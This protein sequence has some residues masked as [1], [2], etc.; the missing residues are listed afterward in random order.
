MSKKEKIDPEYYM[1]K[2]PVSKAIRYMAIPMI[3]MTMIDVIYNMTDAYFI[4]M[5]N[6]TAMLA[7]ITLAMPF[8]V[9][10]MAISMLFSIGGS[11]FVSRLMGEKNTEKTKLVS[12]TSFWF[13][14]ISGAIVGVV[15]L[16]FLTPL[17]HLFGAGGDVFPYAR[18]YV[19]ILAAGSPFLIA[20]FVLS[21][22][23]RGEGASKVALMGLL[24]SVLAN[25]ILDP[26]FIFGLNGGI[27]GAAVALIV[28]N[29][30]SVS[31]YIY[32]ITS[33]SRVESVSLK[34]FTPSKE[35]LTEIF[36]VGVGGL[37]MAGFMFISMLVFNNY[38]AMYGDAAVAGFGVGFR[39]VQISDAV[40]MGITEGVVPLIA[41]AYSAG[42][43]V[44]LKE[45]L[46]KTAIYLA[47]VT[48]LMAV[49]LSVIR[50]PL[51]GL[52][53]SDPEVISMGGQVLTIMLLA[54]I[55][56]AFASFFEGIFQA[57]GKGMQ[58]SVMGI[59]RGASLMPIVIVMNALFLLNGVLWSS[60]VADVLACALGLVLWYTLKKKGL[61]R[62]AT[63]A[64]R[65]DGQN[66]IAEGPEV[67]AGKEIIQATN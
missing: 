26:I 60:L 44:R 56:A 24:I 47:S 2:A 11:T 40:G 67:T 28:G 29:I 20:N 12:S 6:N 4:G 58:S 16:I 55:F 45:L 10:T 14:V 36:K 34:H 46:R 65:T 5:L 50:S 57:F 62:P 66:M 7:A 19:M 53:S 42:N 31:Y 21:G 33:K 23:I 48:I 8:M 15:C 13:S 54:T 59:V 63:G 32:H 25:L 22:L 51:I 52:F 17:V 35:I 61:E 49:I 27:M 39:V 64:D 38:F 1:E 30:L 37:M 41:Y 18:D 9:L 3:L 43:F